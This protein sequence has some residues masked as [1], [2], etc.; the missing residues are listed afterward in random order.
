MI[1]AGTFKA[2]GVEAALAV[3][4]NGSEQVAVQFVLLE[5]PDEGKHITYYGYFTDKTTERTIDSLRLCGWDGDDL[6]DLT[7]IDANEVYLVIEHDENDK[8]EARATVRWI[9]GQ[10]GGLAVKERMDEGT[11]K[12]FAERMKGHVL[13]AK[14]RTRGAPASTRQPA[15]PKAANGGK[16]FA[17]TDDIPF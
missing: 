1:E 6:S 9:N 7:G 15:P 5:G 13:A 4:G 8:G 12:A 10:G 11:A 14:Q 3:A 17:P 2:R 16:D